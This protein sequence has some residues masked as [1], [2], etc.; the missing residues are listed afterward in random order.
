MSFKLF[1]FDNI[2]FSKITKNDDFSLVPEPVE[3]LILR[4]WHNVYNISAV[5]FFLESVMRA[6]S[7]IINT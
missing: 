3:C 1:L 5:S 2:Y 7:L 4:F 6:Y